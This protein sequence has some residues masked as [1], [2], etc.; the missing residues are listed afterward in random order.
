MDMK[1]G[2]ISEPSCYFDT[3]DTDTGFEPVFDSFCVYWVEFL[4]E[5]KNTLKLWQLLILILIL[6]E[7]S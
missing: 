2:Q 5:R 4:H 6:P 3:A 1:Y 7:Q